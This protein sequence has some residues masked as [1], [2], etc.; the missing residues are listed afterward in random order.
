M[1]SDFD[2]LGAGYEASVAAIYVRLLFLARMAIASSCARALALLGG[3]SLTRYDTPISDSLAVLGCLRQSPGVV[4]VHLCAG[5]TLKGANAEGACAI[6][7][8]K[9]GAT[10]LIL[11]F[12]VQATLSL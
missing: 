10:M 5:A 11:L 1:V 8:L 2:C 6:M 12:S 9:K 7:R 3:T 4:A